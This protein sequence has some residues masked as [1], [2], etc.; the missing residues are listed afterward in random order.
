MFARK[1]NSG[2]AIGASTGPSGST[3]RGLVLRQAL[4]RERYI[5]LWA[6]KNAERRIPNGETKASPAAAVAESEPDLA[7]TL[8]THAVKLIASRVCLPTT[9]GI[10]DA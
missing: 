10:R 7:A 9:R 5:T 2:A 1:M 4:P 8:V 6:L 3:F